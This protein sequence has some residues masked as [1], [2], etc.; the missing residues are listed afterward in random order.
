[1]FVFENEEGTKTVIAK[2]ELISCL[3]EV[4]KGTEPPKIKEIVTQKQV[5]DEESAANYYI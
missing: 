3:S 4:S 1:M 2:S 5:G